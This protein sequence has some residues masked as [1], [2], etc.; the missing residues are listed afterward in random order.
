M[1]PADT[2]VSHGSLIDE[3]CINQ[4]NWKPADDAVRR[5]ISKLNRGILKKTEKETSHQIQDNSGVKLKTQKSSNWTRFIA[6]KQH[7]FHGFNS[8]RKNHMHFHKETLTDAHV[9]QSMCRK[10]NEY[11]N[12]LITTFCFVEF[13][14]TST[15]VRARIN[16]SSSQFDINWNSCDSKNRWLDWQQSI[17]RD[18]AVPAKK[19]ILLHH[20]RRLEDF[21]RVIREK[22]HKNSRT[23]KAIERLIFQMN[24]LRTRFTTTLRNLAFTVS[25]AKWFRIKH[26]ALKNRL[27]EAVERQDLYLSKTLESAIFSWKLATNS[28]NSAFSKTDKQSLKNDMNKKWIELRETL[29]FYDALVDVKV[30]A[31]RLLTLYYNAF[32]AKSLSTVPMEKSELLQSIEDTEYFLLLSETKVQLLKST[33]A[34]QRNDR[35]NIINIYLAADKMNIAKGMLRRSTDLREMEYY[36]QNLNSTTIY[37]SSQC[38][39]IG[40]SAIVDMLPDNQTCY[41]VENQS[42]EQGTLFRSNILNNSDDFELELAVKLLASSILRKTATN[43]LVLLPQ[44]TTT[45]DEMLEHEGEKEKNKPRLALNNLLPM[46]RRHNTEYVKRYT[47]S[48]MRNRKED[49]TSLKNIRAADALR[50]KSTEI[51][52][53]IQAKTAE[54]QNCVDNGEEDYNPGMHD[55]SRVSSDMQNICKAFVDQKLKEATYRRN[56][57]LKKKNEEVD[58]VDGNEK[59]THQTE[60]ILEDIRRTRSISLTTGESEIFRQCKKLIKEQKAHYHNVQNQKRKRR[61]FNLGL[62]LTEKDVIPRIDWNFEHIVD[63]LESMRATN[64]FDK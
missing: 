60:A 12:K 25:P 36:K 31:S 35:I 27:K 49:A 46:M 52:N 62:E 30:F 5:G 33:E 18:V 26:E 16:D 58:A 63:A 1:D 59:L 48:G 24:T 39:K 23:R 38:R 64:N 57:L 10:L 50:I 28:Y 53:S 32:K 44:T 8:K 7:Q 9:K 14:Q 41:H 34:A 37:F 19:K 20:T 29:Q 4:H 3:Q 43:M 11:W 6:F 42:M 22:S 47:F 51:L 15:H 17:I 2:F 61:F 40:L 13:D 56:Q 55:I 45:I 21:I 54:S